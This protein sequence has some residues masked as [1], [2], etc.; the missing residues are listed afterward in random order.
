MC[1]SVSLRM[2]IILHVHTYMW[3]M[4]LHVVY[5]LVLPASVRTVTDAERAAKPLLDEKIRD[6]AL[7]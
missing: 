4:Y 6:A 1:P 3:H 2:H 5:N 7:T